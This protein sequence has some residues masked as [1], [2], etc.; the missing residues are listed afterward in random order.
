MLALA[1]IAALTL[2]PPITQF[3]T[4]QMDYFASNQMMKVES[5]H[6]DIY[7]N[8]FILEILMD[9]YDENVRN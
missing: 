8:A 6:R 2:D 7:K 9:D 4:E 3:T 1:L 5:N